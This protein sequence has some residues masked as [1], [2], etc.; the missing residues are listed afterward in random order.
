MTRGATITTAIGQEEEEERR[1]RKGE[2]ER[3]DREKIN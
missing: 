3:M 1:K 2:M